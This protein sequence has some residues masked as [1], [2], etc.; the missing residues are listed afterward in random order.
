MRT[1]KATCKESFSVASR[2]SAGPAG[3]AVAV[4]GPV[5]SG[6]PRQSTQSENGR[7]RRTH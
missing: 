4:I 5:L 6:Q 3:T 1:S 2:A 7:E